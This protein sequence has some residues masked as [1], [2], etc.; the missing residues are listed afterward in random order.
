[1]GLITLIFLALGLTADAFAV[2]VSNGM[3]YC[4]VTKKNAIKTGLIF[5][6]FQALM[7]MSGYYLGKSFSS[8]VQRYQ[9]WIA[10]IL[11]SIIGINMLVEAYKDRN[12][13]DTSHC[14]DSTFTVKK[15]LVQGVATSIDALAAGVSFAVL[16]INIFTASILI[17]CITLCCCIVGVYIGRIFGALLG[18]RA[19]FLG[20]FILIFIGLKIFIENL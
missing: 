3:C 17:G 18:L 4:N 6:F 13:T 15:L 20:G 2:S 16:D 9:H 8:V 5:G 14:S 12:N 11:L 7:P 19:R 10:L 1:M